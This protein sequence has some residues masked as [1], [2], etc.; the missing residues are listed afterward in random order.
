MLEIFALMALAQIIP[1]IRLCDAAKAEWSMHRPDV[2]ME[3]FL[4]VSLH[5]IRLY[6]DATYRKVKA[7]CSIPVLASAAGDDVGSRG[8]I[9]RPVSVNN[10]IRT[11]QLLLLNG[12]DFNLHVS[13]RGVLA[14]KKEFLP[15]SPESSANGFG[16]SGNDRVGIVILDITV[17]DKKPVQR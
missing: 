13:V 15:K 5:G 6:S 7:R 16:H 12:S 14:I 3:G 8:L 2:E 9:K 4:D 10:F 17:L 11:H 1:S